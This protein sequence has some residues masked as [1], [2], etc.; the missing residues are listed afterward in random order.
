M[1]KYWTTYLKHLPSFT[2][3]F[4]FNIHRENFM[5]RI[6][7]FD[8]VFL[9]RGLQFGLFSFNGLESLASIDEYVQSR[10]AEFKKDPDKNHP[11]K[12][13]HVGVWDENCGLERLFFLPSEKSSNPGLHRAA[14]SHKSQAVMNFNNEINLY[15]DDLQGP[16]VDDALIWIGIS[17]SSNI[18]WEEL[19]I[20][21]LNGDTWADCQTFDPPLDNRYWAYQCT[22]R[23]NSFLREVKTLVEQ[24]E[25]SVLLEEHQKEYVTEQ[26][27][28]LDGKIVYQE[29]LNDGTTVDI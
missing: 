6:L 5:D 17:S 28:L 3:E 7:E 13:L 27:I 19:P 1:K 15:Y 10:R 23:F 18:W 8:E 4:S 29:D 26:G 11:L 22:P 24:F 16:G 21:I 2:Y 12:L 25:G 14:I 9:K 20:T